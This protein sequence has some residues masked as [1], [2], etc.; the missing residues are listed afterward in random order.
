M[1]EGLQ[2]AAST[3][4]EE[5]GVHPH[6]I[7]L[8]TVYINVSAFLLLESNSGIIQNIKYSIQTEL[9]FRESNF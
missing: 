4:A 2:E 8:A 7:H 5:A 3:V 9:F 1:W 6:S